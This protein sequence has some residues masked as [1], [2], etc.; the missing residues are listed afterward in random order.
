MDYCRNCHDTQCEKLNNIFQRN[1][2]LIAKEALTRFITSINKDW[3]GWG[4]E[5]RT[6]RDIKCLLNRK[7]MRFP[8]T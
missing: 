7:F 1:R 2:P 4:E 3:V 8:V 6:G 5:G